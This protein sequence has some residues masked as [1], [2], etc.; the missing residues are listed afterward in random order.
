[1]RCRLSGDGF[2]R[3]SL[4]L[5]PQGGADGVLTTLMFLGLRGERA[6]H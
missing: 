2:T 5:V 6:G 4:K 1:M 3:G